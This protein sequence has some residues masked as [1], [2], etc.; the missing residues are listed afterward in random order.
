VTTPAEI[1]RET[2]RQLATRRVQPTPDNYAALYRE[3]SGEPEASPAPT[4]TLEASSTTLTATPARNDESEQALQSLLSQVLDDLRLFTRDEEDLDAAVL[5]V[6]REARA[7]LDPD[8]LARVATLLAEL[9]PRLR[10]AAR[11]NEA[12]HDG[13]VRLLQM[14]VRTARDLAADNETLDHLMEAVQELLAQELDLPTI[15]QAERNLRDVLVKHGVLRQGLEDVKNTLQE[16]V[17]RFIDRLGDFSA[18]TTGYH[19]KLAGYAHQIAVTR[20]VGAL[21]RVLQELMHDTRVMQQDADTSR[22]EMI[23]ARQNVEATQARIRSLEDDLARAMKKI[24]EDKLTGAVNRYGF[25]DDFAQAAAQADAGNRPLCVALLDVD[26][27]KQLNDV[28]GHQGGDE[29]LVYLAG[30]IRDTVRRTDTVVRYG[31]EEFLILL[32]DTEREAAREL[33]VRLQRA[34]TRHLF[35]HKNENVVITFSC[36]VAQRAPGEARDAVIE[37]ADQAMYE[38]KRAGKNRVHVAA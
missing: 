36:G 22:R 23:A 18:N 32:P 14:M 21:G 35:F 3:I 25:E 8:R 6:A 34:L 31:G 11:E 26:N 1:A 28:H 37:R 30:V 38:A 16:M 2:L 29:A 33:V 19:D 13:L 15:E 10:R 17:S 24:R 9:Q 4:I 20:D 12:V 5:L 27:F 7:H